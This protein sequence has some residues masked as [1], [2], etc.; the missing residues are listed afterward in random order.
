ML[1]RISQYGHVII[2]PFL[3]EAFGLGPDDELELEETENGFTLKLTE[4]Q[5]KPP[6]TPVD[7]SKYGTLR[8]KIP[9]GFP[10]LSMSEIR[11]RMYAPPD[12]WERCCDSAKRRN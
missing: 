10:H 5:I 3:L 12:G 11:D 6:P 2:P 7:L 1:V 9:P 4:G 8:D